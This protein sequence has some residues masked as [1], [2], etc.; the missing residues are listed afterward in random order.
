MCNKKDFETIRYLL[1]NPAERTNWRVLRYEISNTKKRQKSGQRYSSGFTTPSDDECS[2]REISVNIDE[3][4]NG[5]GRKVAARVD[6]GEAAS[7]V[8]TTKAKSSKMQQK[9]VNDGKAAADSGTSKAKLSKK[10]TAK[11]A[12]TAKSF[13][14]QSTK[15]TK[16]TT[17]DASK[18][19][20]PP[21]KLSTEKAG[22]KNSQK[23]TSLG[24]EKGKDHVME[25][26][27]SDDDSLDLDN[28]EGMREAM[29]II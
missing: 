12:V 3:T 9:K 7:E 15:A 2:S 26:N 11:K 19:A 21:K 17:K 27:D 16:K 13:Q 24:S 10:V 8:G 18:K 1:K 6:D 14:N 25:R 4:I 22:Q 29:T 28:M 23:K 20:K 5:H